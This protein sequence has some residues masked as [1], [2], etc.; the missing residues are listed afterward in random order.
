M[1]NEKQGKV[2]TPKPVYNRKLMRS[3][4]RA[5]IKKRQGQHKISRTMSEYFKRTR[6]EQVN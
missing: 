4:I 1:V 2:Y 6:K 5:E 3:V